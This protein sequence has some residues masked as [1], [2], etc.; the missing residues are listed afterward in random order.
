M[1]AAYKVRAKRQKKTAADV[2]AKRN[3]SKQ[4][5]A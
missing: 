1:T 3:R 4:L 2:V 5:S